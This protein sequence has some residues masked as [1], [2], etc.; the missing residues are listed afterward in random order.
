MAELLRIDGTVRMQDILRFGSISEIK[1]FLLMRKKDREERAIEAEWDLVRET[2]RAMK[3]VRE[4]SVLRRRIIE[5]EVEEERKRRL[6]KEQEELC[7]V[8]RTLD[9]RYRG[10]ERYMPVLIVQLFFVVFLLKLGD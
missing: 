6:K 5:L 4:E 2:E 3:A 7:G 8:L 9:I 10:V 1:W